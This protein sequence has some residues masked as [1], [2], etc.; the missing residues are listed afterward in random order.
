MF[1]FAYTL[2]ISSSA[3]TQT[4]SSVEVNKYSPSSDEEAE[5]LTPIEGFVDQFELRCLYLPC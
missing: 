3:R 4:A 5:S 2:A 1:M